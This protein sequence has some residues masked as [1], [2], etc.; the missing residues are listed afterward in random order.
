[1]SSSQDKTLVDIG[2]HWV[3]KNDIDCL[4]ES[5]HHLNSQVI[6]AYIRVLKAISRIQ[7]RENGDVY[8]E[9]TDQANM[10]CNDTVASLKDKDGNYFRL[11]R[12]LTYL[13][14]DMVFFPINVTKITGIWWLSMP[15][16]VPY[17]FLTHWA[18]PL[19]GLS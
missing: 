16:N 4:L 14:H 1:M 7:K 19:V 9:T 5:S 13:R 12:T 10:I 3:T 11:R 2:T 8:L 6:N 15:Q 18:L 17:R